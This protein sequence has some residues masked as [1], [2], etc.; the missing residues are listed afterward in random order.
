[1]RGH[2]ELMLTAFAD[3]KLEIWRSI[4][5][6]FVFYLQSEH[7]RWKWRHPIFTYAADLSGRGTSLQELSLPLST[8]RL[9]G[10]PARLALHLTLRS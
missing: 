7:C 1:M 10:K 3:S 8:Q 6:S 5:I 4:E 2:T 9:Q